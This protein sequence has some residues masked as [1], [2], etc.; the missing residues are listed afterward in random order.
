[1]KT[2]SEIYQLYLVTDREL[3]STKTL[4]E[5]VE[6]AIDGGCTMVQLREKNLSSRDFY[7]TAKAL[8]EFLQTRGVPLIINDR[9]D[10]ALAVDADGV[11][12][13][14]S[15]LPLHEARKILGNERIIGVT[16]PTLPLALE[17]ENNGADYL[18]VGAVFGTTTKKDAKK[19]TIEI[20]SEIAHTVKIPVVAIG[21]I[22]A[23]SVT[24]K[25][26]F[27]I[28]ANNTYCPL[29]KDGKSN[30][31]KKAEKLKLE[32][33]DIEVI[34]ENVFYDMFEDN[35]QSTEKN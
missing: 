29:I 8:K 7:N 10:I 33:Y 22:N 2:N 14:Q 16:A 31:Q 30:K 27:L 4:E 15:D 18:G 34:P 1:M 9:V 35:M 13:G 19:N 5:A 25:T 23:D 26:N 28:L 17:A 32:G 6:K 24:K 11:H 3:M 21:G 20:L 12:I